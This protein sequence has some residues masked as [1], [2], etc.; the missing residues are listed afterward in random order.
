MTKTIEKE[1]T[2]KEKMDHFMQTLSR[3]FG[4]PRKKLD[5]IMFFGEKSSQNVLRGR[6]SSKSVAK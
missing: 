5:E 2:E 4:I 1:K 6:K 3:V